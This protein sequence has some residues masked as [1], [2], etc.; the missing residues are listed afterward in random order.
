MLR[1]LWL[2]GCIGPNVPSSHF[3]FF[4]HRKPLRIFSIARQ[5]FA[6]RAFGETK[7]RTILCFAPLQCHACASK[8]K[9]CFFCVL[10]GSTQTIFPPYSLTICPSR[11]SGFSRLASF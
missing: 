1:R 2:D 5:I 3:A 9:T 4:I 8:F 6:L 10:N 7:M 11:L